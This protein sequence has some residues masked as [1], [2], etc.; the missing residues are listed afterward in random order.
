MA[1]QMI[2]WPKSP[3]TALFMF[4][5]AQ[6]KDFDDIWQRRRCL[7]SCWPCS[8]LLRHGSFHRS[9]SAAVRWWRW[10]RRQR[11]YFPWPSSQCGRND[12]SIDFAILCRN[13]E[14]IQPPEGDKKWENQ[15][16]FFLNVDHVLNVEWKIF[17]K[18]FKEFK[19]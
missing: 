14:F 3:Q 6:F 8:V 2:R 4:P 5:V 15:W 18:I 13:P 19:I 16:S 10:W 1:F 9:R 12:V 7:L 11:K 17:N